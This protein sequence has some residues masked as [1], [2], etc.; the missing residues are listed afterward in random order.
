M[1]R[2]KIKGVCFFKIAQSARRFLLFVLLL[3][4]ISLN[5]YEPVFA[6]NNSVLSVRDSVV[7]VV[8]VPF[9]NGNPVVELIGYGTGIVVGDS[10]KQYVLTNRHV[11]EW[12]DTVNAIRSLLGSNYDVTVVLYILS[13]GYSTVRIPVSSGKVTLSNS[14]DMA[15]ISL[16]TTLKNRKAAVF[17]RSSDLKVTDKVYAIG[18]PKVAEQLI[19]KHYYDTTIFETYLHQLFPS[20]VTDMTVTDGTISKTRAKIEGCYYVQHEAN[21]S[22]GNSGGPLVD[23]YGHVI[24]INTLM[25]IDQSGTGSKEHY[26]ITVSSI[27]S[28]LERNNVSFKTGTVIGGVIK[29]NLLFIVAAIIVILIA[30]DYLNEIQKTKVDSGTESAPTTPLNSISD[31]LTRIY[32]SPDSDKLMVLTNTDYFIEELKKYY[33]PEFRNDCRILEKA[34]RGGLGKIILQYQNQKEIP[35]YSDK[36][37]IIEQMVI[38]CGLSEKDAARAMALF[39]EMVGWDSSIPGTNT[40]SAYG[41]GS[42]AS[43]SSSAIPISAT[44]RKIYQNADQERLLSDPDYFVEQLSGNYRPE[45]KDDCRLLEKAARSGLGLIVLQYI[46]QYASPSDYEADRLSSEL[47]NRSGFSR[48]EAERAIRLYGD[49]VGWSL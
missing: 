6:K 7:R 13:E 5:V 12:S 47:C 31:V 2:Y 22:P 8:N 32:S 15:L 10:K 44:L 27:R 39:F 11:A 19:D 30:R 43:G 1:W 48:K 14:E 46:R 16:D 25:S 42:T 20:D 36:I 35:G 49:M 29:N 3:I 9:V 17:G 41:T 18:F 34:S 23:N 4:L 45:Y 40:T 37:T 26:A 33:Q 28:F 24:G 38:R 21:I